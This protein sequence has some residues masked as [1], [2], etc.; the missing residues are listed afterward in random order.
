MA[1]SLGWDSLLQTQCTVTV[2]D[3][4]PLRSRAGPLHVSTQSPPPVSDDLRPSL[5]RTDMLTLAGGR[6]GQDSEISRHSGGKEGLGPA[7]ERIQTLQGYG[8]G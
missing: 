3:T 7:L 5:S 1:A 4:R 6:C 2:R 8:G